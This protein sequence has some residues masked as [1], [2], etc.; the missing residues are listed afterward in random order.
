MLKLGGLLAVIAITLA[1]CGGD[2]DS[3]TTVI[4]ETP[5]EETAT[6]EGPSEAEFIRAADRQCHEFNRQ[7][8]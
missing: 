2:D 8:D 5:G 6:E 1:A 4:Q 7:L 3:T